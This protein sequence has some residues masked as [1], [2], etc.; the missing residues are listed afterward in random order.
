MAFDHQEPIRFGSIDPD[1]LLYTHGKVDEL[2]QGA[3]SRAKQYVDE[4]TSSVYR[5]M[6]SV[7]KFENL[8]TTGR[9]PGHVYDVVETGDNYAWAEDDDG[10]NG[11]WDNLGP[12][13]SGYQKKLTAGAGI[14]I[15]DDEVA[16][17]DGGVVT[18][19]IG[20]KQVTGARIADNTLENRNFSDNSIAGGR[21]QANTITGAV[22]DQNPGVAAGKLAYGTVGTVN[23]RD[24]AV[25]NDKLA[26]NAVNGAK[27]ANLSV[28]TGK[29]TNKAVTTAKLDDNAV[30][31]AENGQDTTVASGKLAY[32]TVGTV[33][34]RDSAVT[35]TK[36]NDSAV[37]TDKIA[38]NAVTGAENNQDTATAAGKLAYSTVGTVNLRDSA[39]TEAKLASG[40]VSASK[41]S[42]A[43]MRE[44]NGKAADANVLHKTGAESAAGHKTFTAALTVGSRNSENAAGAQSVGEGSGVTA[45]ATNT[46]A[47]GTNTTASGYSAHAEGG[48][49]EASGRFS[50][51]EGYGTKALPG[52]SDSAGHGTHAEGVN[53]QAGVGAERGTYSAGLNGV[54]AH[55][56]GGGTG[57]S[58][59]ASHAEG[60][61]SLATGIGSHA[62]GIGTTANNEGEHA[63]GKYNVSNSNTIHSIGIGTGTAADGPTN[64]KNAVEVL[65]DGK[66]YVIGVGGY[67]GTSLTGATDLKT[68][69]DGKAAVVQNPTEDNFAS[70]DASGNLK[71][72]NSKA[73]DF[74]RKNDEDVE[75]GLNASAAAGKR[76][77]IAIGQLASA[78]KDGAVAI[79]GLSSS[80]QATNAEAT[81]DGS[82]AL[83]AGAKASANGSAQI[84]YSASAN[85]DANTLRF[86]DTTI[87]DSNGRIVS[88]NLDK[89]VYSQS[90]ID[91]AFNYS[92]IA[93]SY[94]S[95]NDSGTSN[96]RVYELGTS[97]SSVTLRWKANKTPESLTIT[98]SSPS[99]SRSAVISGDSGS[100]TISFTAV[101]PTNKTE[102]TFKASAVETKVVA[103]PKATSA[104]V[105]AKIAF[106][107]KMFY[108]SASVPES[109]TKSFVEGLGGSVESSRSITKTINASGAGKYIFI[110]IPG[111]YAP[112]G[113]SQ[114]AFSV[115]GF[116]GGINHV[117]T[118]QFTTA[119]GYNGT[120]YIYKSDNANLG[121]TQVVIS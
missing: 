26:T 14:S 86:R 69:I 87:V 63:E 48:A 23:L 61:R 109:Y 12:N 29:L 98:S 88:D 38:N 80:N 99:V 33:N 46:H 82:I 16:I 64:P 85:A 41:L 21:I 53:T 44:L 25:T 92:K 60:L 32:N 74:V 75:I 94:L 58:G 68:V 19:M 96:S 62:E 50:H 121:S 77:T 2:V 24:A 71:D 115:G 102:Y 93:I 35:E 6:G 103:H 76:N 9:V 18:S 114:P 11:H 55:A 42:S 100:E 56:E 84:G 7:Q 40:A 66:V 119:A 30:T 22:N 3:E 34:L 10:S 31:G 17:K 70:F 113:T 81:G 107:A 8:P 116:A 118:L 37:S 4:K 90:E 108:G 13:M 101:K 95:P 20:T 45:S 67:L 120:Y 79:G 52:Q 89:A 28:S 36:I 54:A 72:S 91:E 112:N 105:S 27:I 5:F 43:V 104:E 106:H 49:S 110:A 47:E 83:G 59:R 97:L 57:A 39:V 117:S 65:N 15:D 78:T 73:G 111:I 51:A 1:E